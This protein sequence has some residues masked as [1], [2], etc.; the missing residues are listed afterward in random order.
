MPECV[1]E[2]YRPVIAQAK[3]YMS[4]YFDME[5]IIRMGVYRAGSNP[6]TDAAIH[7]TELLEQFLHQA[8]DEAVT[9]EGSYEELARILSE[10][11]WI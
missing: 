1:P 2:Q 3:T 10:T 8:K 4:T 6:Q 9:L 7:Y 5:E 11:Q